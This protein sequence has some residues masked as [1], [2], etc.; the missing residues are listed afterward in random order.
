MAV[1]PWAQFFTFMA[2]MVV[3]RGQDPGRMSWNSELRA[4]RPR[5]VLTLPRGGNRAVVFLVGKVSVRVY[6]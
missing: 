2:G 3:N 4:T 5:E 6:F 1:G